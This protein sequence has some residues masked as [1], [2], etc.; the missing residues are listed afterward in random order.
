MIKTSLNG[1]SRGPPTVGYSVRFPCLGEARPRIR[2]DVAVIISNSNPQLEASLLEAA[3][4]VMWDNDFTPV[5]SL[6]VFDSQSF[7]ASLEKGFSFYRKVAQEG[8]SL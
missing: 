4:Q 7:A 1:H 3:Y 5:I 8:I 2:P 6:N